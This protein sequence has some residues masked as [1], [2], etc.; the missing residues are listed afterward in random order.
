M[1]ATV[2]CYV[3]KESW[4]NLFAYMGPGFLVSIAY[5]DPGN[6]K[7]ISSFISFCTLLFFS[8]F[9]CLFYSITN[10]ILKILFCYSQ[11][12]LIYNL[13]QST[14]MGYVAGSFG[15]SCFTFNNHQTHDFVVEG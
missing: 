6:C 14:S 9:F 12:R 2:A 7:T 5:I 4:K 8:F 3:Q 13:V 1:R 11:L 10:G 15:Y